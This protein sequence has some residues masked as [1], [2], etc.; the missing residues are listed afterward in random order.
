MQR[1][2]E[3]KVYALDIWFV[4][5]NCKKANQKSYSFTCKFTVYALAVN[6]C[7]K[8]TYMYVQALNAG[9]ST[10]WIEP[11]LVK[12]G[13]RE[14]VFSAASISAS[15]CCTSAW[16]LLSRT[17]RWVLPGFSS[18]KTLNCRTRLHY[19][20]PANITVYNSTTRPFRQLVSQ[21]NAFHIDRTPK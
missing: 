12:S 13:M 10:D 8:N 19:H 18:E 7:T 21:F 9:N 16:H 6:T 17:L 5:S 11:M 14:D 1:G 4:K 20:R 2:T 15:V 3:K